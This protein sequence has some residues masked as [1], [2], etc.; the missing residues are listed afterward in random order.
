MPTNIGPAIVRDTVRTRTTFGF[1]KLFGI[2][3]ILLLC[4]MVEVA[5]ESYFDP[6]H[7]INM[8]QIFV[9]P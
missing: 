1:V 4:A 5:A 3:T 2:L 9:A 7:R 6:D 8:Q